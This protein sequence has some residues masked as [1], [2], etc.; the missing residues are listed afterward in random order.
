[1]NAPISGRLKLLFLIHS[2]VGLFLGLGIVFMPITMGDW[3]SLPIVGTVF[4]R[5]VGVAVMS[6]GLS[7]ALAYFQNRFESIKLLVQLEII[8]TLLATILLAWGAI[9]I[10][11]FPNILLENIDSARLWMWITTILMGIFFLAYAGCYLFD[12]RTETG[13][14]PRYAASEA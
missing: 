13:T 10:D 6:F 12:E 8:W 3:F 5:L 1:M 14:E 11:Q 2:I 4:E 9:T 7:S